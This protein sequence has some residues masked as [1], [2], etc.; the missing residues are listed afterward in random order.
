MLEQYLV[1]YMCNNICMSV[2]KLCYIYSCYE[3]VGISFV[4]YIRDI[5]NDIRDALSLWLQQL[6]RGELPDIFYFYT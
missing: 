6:I 4:A 5:S 2:Y 3:F 1:I